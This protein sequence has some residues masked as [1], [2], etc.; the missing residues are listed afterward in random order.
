MAKA[1]KIFWIVFL[2]HNIGLLTVAIV[3]DLKEN[4]LSFLINLKGYI[5][6]VKYIALFGFLLF[7][8]S[9]LL[10]ILGTRK[11]KKEMKKLEQEKKELK[12]KMFDLQEAQQA[13]K[14]TSAIESNSEIMGNGNLEQPSE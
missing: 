2:I 11:I 5:P 4:D 14:P 9:F 10:S 3:M 1:T 8:T 13:E 12:A 6:L 7:L